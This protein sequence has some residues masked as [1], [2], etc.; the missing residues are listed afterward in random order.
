MGII[1]VCKPT[2]NWGSPS[3][4]HVW[5]YWY[6]G[7]AYSTH[8]LFFHASCDGCTKP[9]RPA[10]WSACLSCDMHII[11]SAHYVHFCMHVMCGLTWTWG[12]RKRFDVSFSS[13]C[14]INIATLGCNMGVYP[15]PETIG[16]I[17]QY[18]QHTQRTDL[19]HLILASCNLKH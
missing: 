19:L 6:L 4:T 9:K 7:L 14:S 16:N 5:L 17:S 15:F 12:I 10:V 11:L 18:I 1:M 8:N 3:C 13:S 2:Y